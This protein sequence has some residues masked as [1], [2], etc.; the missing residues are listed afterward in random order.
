MLAILSARSEYWCVTLREILRLSVFDVAVLKSLSKRKGE[1]EAVQMNVKVK[2]F[3]AYVIKEHR[4]SRSG[5]PLVWY[6][7]V[8]FTLWPFYFQV[9]TSVPVEK[10]GWLGPR[11]EREV[12]GKIFLYASWNSKSEFF[13]VTIP[14][15]MSRIS[16]KL[17]NEGFNYLYFYQI[18]LTW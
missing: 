12:L 17:S 6:K 3:F 13:L 18:S 7:V 11:V 14:N 8:I 15:E 9:R 16:R 10:Q 2:I 4:N 5:I 1:K